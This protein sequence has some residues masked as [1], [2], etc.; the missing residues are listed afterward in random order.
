MT[1][2]L[3]KTDRQKANKLGKPTVG[4]IS[5]KKKVHIYNR[6][7]LSQKPWKQAVHSTAAES[8][9]VPDGSPGKV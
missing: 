5:L 6:M 8:L 2:N 1:A 9:K 3:C 7:K 4:V